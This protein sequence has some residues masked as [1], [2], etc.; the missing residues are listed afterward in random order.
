M[1]WG[2]ISKATEYIKNQTDAVISDI[3]PDF[4]EF[5][6][7]VSGDTASWARDRIG[8]SVGQSHDDHTTDNHHGDRQTCTPCIDTSDNLKK[9]GGSYR[10]KAKFGKF[11][12]ACSNSV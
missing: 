8:L 1:S 11:S 12:C 4:K 10:F 3:G 6:A 7:T 9:V 5:A 2:W